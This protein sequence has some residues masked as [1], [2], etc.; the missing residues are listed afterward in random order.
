MDYD[1]TI[2][3][4]HTPEWE[5][6]PTDDTC[7]VVSEMSIIN[8]FGHDLSIEDA[9][10]ISS[11]N[12]WYM[13][14]EGTSTAHI[15]NMMDLYNIPNH[16]VT[17]ASIADLAA[18]LQ[19][20]HG[21][22]VGVNSE[23]LWSSGPLEEMWLSIKSALGLDT[24]LIAPADHAIVVTGIDLSDPNNPQVI[25]NDSGHPDGEAACYPL[26]KFMDAWQNSDF[27]YTATDQAMPGT[28]TNALLGADFSNW[29][30]ELAGGV[31]AISSIALG[32]DPGSAAFIGTVSEDMVETF[33]NTPG[34]IDMI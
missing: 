11:S 16:T 23:E 17:N 13:P 33:F 1:Y 6:Q 29:L 28:D 34:S 25:I 7:A 15:G 24:S 5:L 21:V 32:A 26:D 30:P 20:G 2:Q 4:D 10:Y 12:G 19:A 14:G 22:I 8:Q 27:Y 18:E 31:A 9:A 3:P